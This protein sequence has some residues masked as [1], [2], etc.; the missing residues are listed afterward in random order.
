MKSKKLYYRVVG[1]LV[2]LLGAGYVL[3]GF[4]ATSAGT[5]LMK[6][7]RQV[8]DSVYHWDSGKPLLIMNKDGSTGCT[9]VPQHGEQR[10]LS[11]YGTVYRDS[12][13]T[14]DPWF[15]GSADVT[16]GKDVRVYTGTPLELWKWTHLRTRVIISIVAI[17]SPFALAVL[18]DVLFLDKRKRAEAAA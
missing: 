10:S 1:G 12:V 18:V 14:F 15:S 11:T 7:G 5:L 2:V 8:E 6:Q 3:L 9:V 16:C 13:K 17:L 4:Y